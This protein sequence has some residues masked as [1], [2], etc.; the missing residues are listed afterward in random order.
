MKGGSFGEG[1]MLSIS[2]Q[3]FAAIIKFIA[4]NTLV[5]EIL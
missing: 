2:T 5:V 3:S 1:R 4:Y